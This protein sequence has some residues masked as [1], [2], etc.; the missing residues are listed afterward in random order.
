MQEAITQR[1]ESIELVV[2]KLGTALLS[3]VLD[4]NENYLKSLGEQIQFIK[5][6]GRR[7]VV[8]SS[9]AVGL[10]RKKLGYD[11]SSHETIPERQA[12]AS[13]G[14]TLLMNAYQSAWEQFDFFPS[15]ILAGKKEF[16]DKESYRNISNTLEQLLTW[17]SVPIINENDAVTVEELR[18]G[19]NDTLAG[20]IASM[21]NQ[22]LLLI[23]SNVDGFY[24][25]DKKVSF[26]QSIG[27]EQ[28]AQ[29]GEASEVGMGGMYTKI[30]VAKK[31]VQAGQAMN[32]A[33]G[34]DPKII[35]KLL[36]GEELGTWFFD[37]TEMLSQ[38]KRW[39]LHNTHVVGVLT[40]DDAA[41]RAL[42]TKKQSLLTSG[43]IKFDSSFKQGELLEI[44][45]LSGELFAKGIASISSSESSSDLESK[46]QTLI[47]IDE[48]VVL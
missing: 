46:N 4:K 35:Q 45:N 24:M 25:N 17:G 43:I 19:D 22:T 42:K 1:I 21:Y 16:F 40:V 39:I 36:Q 41:E 48:L 23:L 28:L 34:R 33:S 27:S 31:L 7:A 12:Y 11:N 20:L 15:Q 47:D 13:L 9:G 6:S 8:V 30:K 18:F 2:I 14:Q 44:C 32:I 38:K 37:D 10:G 5:K 29:A 26:L 3:G